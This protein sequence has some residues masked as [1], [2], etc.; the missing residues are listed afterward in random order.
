MDKK[1]FTITE[2]CSLLDIKPHTIRYWE[3]EFT[4]LKKRSTKGTAR[5]YTPE[6]IEY[7]R[8]IKDLI[9]ERRFTL[10]G[11][12]AEMKKMAKEPPAPPPVTTPQNIDTQMLKE[13]LRQ[14]REM[15]LNRKPTCMKD[16]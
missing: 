1:Y 3:T 7:L 15:L 6:D 8:K 9:Y 4:R 13:S 5:R 14:I 11:A 2:I 16:V 12:K 10:E